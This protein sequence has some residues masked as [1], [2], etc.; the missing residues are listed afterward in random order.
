MLVGHIKWYCNGVF[1]IELSLLL[2]LSTDTFCTLQTF[3]KFW[4]EHKDFDEVFLKFSYIHIME[5]CL[6]M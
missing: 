3:P 6:Y 2:L 4:S 5:N 1:V